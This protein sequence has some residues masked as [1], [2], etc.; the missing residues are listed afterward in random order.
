[1][2]LNDTHFKSVPT[3]VET[4]APPETLETTSALPMTVLV[5]VAV[6]MLLGLIWTARRGI[7]AKA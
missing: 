7:V 4:T 5:V 6:V 1:M 3:P 2:A